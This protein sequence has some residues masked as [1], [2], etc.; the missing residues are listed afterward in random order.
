[1]SSQPILDMLSSARV[2]IRQLAKVAGRGYSH[3]WR[4]ATGRQHLTRPTAERWAAALRE[5]GIKA[6]WQ[7]II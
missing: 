5:L 7:D 4:V 1:M 2:S 3:T 6:A